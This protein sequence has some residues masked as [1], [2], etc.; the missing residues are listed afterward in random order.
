MQTQTA[1][2][3]SQGCPGRPRRQ[4]LAHHVLKGVLDGADHQAL[5]GDGFLQVKPWHSIIGDVPIILC[6]GHPA[7]LRRA[8]PRIMWEADGRRRG[9]L[10]DVHEVPE[11]LTD[12]QMEPLGCHDSGTAARMA[13]KQGP[14]VEIKTLPAL[15][16]E[17]GR[18]SEPERKQM[19]WRTQSSWGHQLR[20]ATQGFASSSQVPAQH[21]Q[22]RCGQLIKGVWTRLVPGLSPALRQTPRAASSASP[23]ASSSEGETRQ[24]QRSG[25]LRSLLGHTGQQPPRAS[26][27]WCTPAGMMA[28]AGREQGQ[29][30][31]EPRESLGT[32]R[33]A[34]IATCPI[35]RP[36][37]GH[38]PCLV[39]ACARRPGSHPIQLPAAFPGRQSAPQA[40][41]PLH[42]HHLAACLVLVVLA[43]P[44]I[45]HPAGRKQGVKALSFTARSSRSHPAAPHPPPTLT[46][47]P[48][49][50]GM[51]SAGA[52]VLS[53]A[54]AARRADVPDQL[55]GLM[56]GQQQH[57]LPPAQLGP[58]ESGR[59]GTH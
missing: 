13:I 30:A 18:S 59:P 49:S 56:W 42:K 19:G 9:V 32:R 14:V 16:G 57:S 47:A 33:C 29:P 11:L 41:P 35:S 7:R 26:Q 12:V 28:G 1:K 15:Q 48:T 36:A 10:Q 40:G 58:G 20:T 44:R 27:P 6:E 54:A 21:G 50:L 23:A 5:V 55:R 43:L 46:R 24:G 4:G 51:L 34:H 3:C 38:P 45:Y 39:P 2:R 53:G 31:R 52:P 25:H 17:K 37:T 22:E 8:G